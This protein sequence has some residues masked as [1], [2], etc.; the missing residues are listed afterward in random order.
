MNRD[1]LI[2]SLGSFIINCWLLFPSSRHTAYTDTNRILMARVLK[3]QVSEELFGNQIIRKSPLAT[4]HLRDL[5]P[6]TTIMA[7]IRTLSWR[8]M[9]I[10]QRKLLCSRATASGYRL[11]KGWNKH[12]FPARAV[13]VSMTE[14]LTPMNHITLSYG[15]M[16]L[17]L[18][19]SKHVNTSS[20]ELL[21]QYFTIV[22]L[23]MLMISLILENWQRFD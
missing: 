11:S 17:V 13:F 22:N 7:L 3:G 21:I 8:W 18:M 23:M 10:L 20:W 6:I 19:N 15:M 2:I 1:H 14:T 9:Q 12:L 5:S 4:H 16:I